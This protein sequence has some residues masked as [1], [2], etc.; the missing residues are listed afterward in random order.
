[1][2]IMFSRPCFLQTASIAG[3]LFGLVMLTV[4]REAE[5]RGGPKPRENDPSFDAEAAIGKCPPVAYVK[6]HHFGKP[7]GV[8]TIYCWKIYRPGCGIYI[9]DPAKPGEGDREIFKSDDGV[10][11]DMEKSYDAK[12]LMFSYMDMKKGDQE[13]GYRGN[14]DS[15]HIY[16]INVDGTGLRQITK[17]RFHDVHPVYLP[18]GRICFVSTRGKS[19]SM[20]Q[21]G[22]SSALFTMNSDG[23]DI[24]RIEF[25]TLADISPYVMDNGTI[26]FM[27]WEYQ[28]KSLFTLQSLWTI[29]PDG[30][31]LELFY[32][33]T[34]TN[35]NVIWQAKQ[36]PGTG[37][38][39]CTLGPHHGKPVGA[40][41]IVDRRHGVE[42]VEGLVNITPEYN[43]TPSKKEHSGG[44][45]GDRQWDWAYRDPWPVNKDV[46]V[47]A[48][49]GLPH[50]DG[51]RYR[52]YVMDYKGNKTLLREDKQISCFNPIP[53]T[54]RKP[55]PVLPPIPESDKEYGT[56]FLTDV[57][58][59]LLDNGIERGAVKEIR[60]ISQVPKRC[61]MRGRRAWDHDPLISRG[62][63]YVKLVHG[64]VPVEE[65]GSAYF[66]APAGVEFYFEAL[67]KDGK[68]VSRMG[69]VTQIMPGELQ[70]CVGCHE[71]RLTAPPRR[72]MST[73]T[74]ARG[75]SEI[76]PPPWGNE[77]LDFVKHVQPVFDKYC[78]KCHS[79]EKPKK[80]LDLSDDK[81]KFFN[82]AYESLLEGKYVHYIYI[83]RGLTDN[84]KPMTTGS[85]V[86]KLTKI[87]ESKEHGEKPLKVSDND[88]RIIYTWIDANCP[89][90]STYENTRPGKDGSRDA[91]SG[92]W[93]GK[94]NNALNA[95]AKIRKLRAP[96]ARERDINLTH[97]EYSQVLIA[98]LAK[99]GGGLAEDDKA[100]F[101]S[102]D[103]A[104]YQAAL[105]AITE[106]R[107]ALYAKPRMDMKGGKPVPYPVDYGGL[108]TGFA[109]P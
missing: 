47:V 79:G 74:L 58:Q 84:F 69:S 77:P 12:K 20:C 56:F 61:N 46:C 15:F 30:T 17:G 25:S 93:V 24:R 4:P 2:M 86:S 27:R 73:K 97:P 102:R 78:V 63:Y 54:S 96:R 8:G 109:G 21:P 64:N 34:I 5:A 90:Y 49:G 99:S 13:P 80:G 100:L 59:G 9:H 89:Y 40:I 6:R 82:M 52:I 45:P 92:P 26:L 83:N 76:T 65:D 44:G 62:S 85:H 31:R 106:A 108:Y 10:I 42:N 104:Q 75:P 107:D 70:S 41:G 55:P 19:Y 66:K 29:N 14:P 39:L 91:W 68:E 72:P 94:F 37:K 35:P 67:D 105:T 36:I 1:M 51:A 81:T 57:Y 103:N 101:E 28:D 43:Y 16:E 22:L 95:Q 87:L 23:S 32:G 11:F 18:D 71:P 7:F 88:R 33:N 50:E 53:L 3:F 48:Y 38:V 60:I 98:N